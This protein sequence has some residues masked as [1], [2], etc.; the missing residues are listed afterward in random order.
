MLEE[1]LTGQYGTWNQCEG[2]LSHALTVSAWR[3]VAGEKVKISC[4][5]SQVLVYLLLQG[6]SGEAEEISVKVL[7]L[8]REVLGEKHPDTIESMTSLAATYYQ[9]GQSGEAEEIYVKVLELRREVLGERHPDTIR[10]HGGT[11]SYISSAGSIRRG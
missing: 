10:E 9:Q 6:R 1:F 7:E 3:E 8:R 4:L 2:L 11:G 5:F